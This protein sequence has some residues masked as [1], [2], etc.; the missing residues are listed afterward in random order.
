M[1]DI[2]ER[3]RELSKARWDRDAWERETTVRIPAEPD[4]DIDLVLASAA[5]QIDRLRARV[6]ELEAARGE[7]GVWLRDQRDSYEGPKTLDPM[8]YLGAADPGRGAHG[9]TYSP[10]YPAPPV[11]AR[12]EP[13]AYL[14]QVVCGDDEPDQALSFAPDN[15]P[16]S[17]VLGYRSLSHVPLYTAP[18]APTVDVDAISDEALNAAWSY[19]IFNAE[20]EQTEAVYDMRAALRAIFNKGE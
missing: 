18:P 15:F 5:E 8:F 16:L 11:Q 4:R 17:G 2:T 10:F 7:P 14:H 9:A 3:L 20:N 19:I 1:A 12:G 13:V 6:A